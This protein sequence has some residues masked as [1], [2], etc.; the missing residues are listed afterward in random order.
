MSRMT[1]AE[2]AGL[3][4]LRRIVMFEQAEFGQICPQDD[5]LPKTEAEV[6][7]FIKRRTALYFESWALPV[8][9][10]LI[11]H[12]EGR[13]VGPGHRILDLIEAGR[14]GG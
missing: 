12:G 8:I 9:E 6:T 2:L 11:A 1:K 13:D 7:A 14:D 4:R 10:E 5:P 3:R